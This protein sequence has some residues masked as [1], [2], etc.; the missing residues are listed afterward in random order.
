MN[1][2]TS[3]DW[4]PV[5]WITTYFGPFVFTAVLLWILIAVMALAV[6]PSDRPWSF[7]WCTLLLLGPFGVA[8]ALI[9]QPR[10]PKA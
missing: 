7:F 5:L 4:D 3:I 9:A 2:K 1:T 8:M 6:A 10:P